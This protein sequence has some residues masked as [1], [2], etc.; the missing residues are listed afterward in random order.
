M[1]CDDYEV[2]DM[3]DAAL[4]NPRVGRLKMLTMSTLIDPPAIP[5]SRLSAG[6]MPTIA[7]SGNAWW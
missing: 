6:C 7:R 5:S 4:K 1:V 3:L 2:L